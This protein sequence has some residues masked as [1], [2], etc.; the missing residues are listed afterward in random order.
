LV[1][2]SH[3]TYHTEARSPPGYI[4]TVAK[5][6]AKLADAKDPAAA[7]N[8]QVDRPLWMTNHQH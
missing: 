4:V 8:Y 2:R 1:V 7:G 6:G 5:D 3:L